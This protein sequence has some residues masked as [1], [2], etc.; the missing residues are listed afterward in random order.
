MRVAD[1]EF[2]ERYDRHKRLEKSGLTLP[3]EASQANA[4]QK[5]A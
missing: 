3:L 5:A 4:M 2:K 1:T